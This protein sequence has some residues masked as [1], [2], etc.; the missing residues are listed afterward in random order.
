MLG[1]NQ[2]HK[3]LR[4][5]AQNSVAVIATLV[6]TAQLAAAQDLIRLPAVADLSSQWG[7]LA[8]A[9]R[10]E[11]SNTA[12]DGVTDGGD[13]GTGQPARSGQRHRITLEQ[14]K[15]QSANRVASP[16]AHMS[17][18][19]VEAARQHRLGVQADYF[20]K[21]G[22]TFV[23]LHFTDFLGQIIQVRRP[24]LGTVTEVPAPIIN[25]NLTIAALT[26]VQ[27]ITPLF[28]VR[29]AVRI[30]RADERI[31]IAKAAASISKNARDSEIEANY[32]KLLIAQR[33][34][35]SAEWK[36]QSAEKRL[37]KASAFVDLVQISGQGAETPGARKEVETAA[38]TVRELAA[39][40]NRVMDWP[41]DTELDLT[42]PDPLVE[43]VSLQEISDKS[44][45]VNPAL[46]EAEQTVVK[47]RA[48]YSISKMAYFPTVAA[49]AG[50]LF[51]NAFP[52]VNSN[53]GYG[54]VM[55]SYTLFDFGKREHAIKE[56]HAQL[57][58][59]ETALQLTKAKI[60]ADVKKSYFELERSRQ[61]SLVA[62]K[63]GSST[64]LLIKV[65]AISESLEV[66]A[67]RAEVE[68]EMI[69]AD[70]AHRQAFNRL[71][72]LTGSER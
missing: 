24:V 30:A 28:E 47:A 52:A 42:M 33:Q 46:V 26:F 62:Q 64:A 4:T 66:K 60:G 13:P 17:Q 20:P 37:Q 21:F 31:A 34:L 10:P 57:E 19:A 39:S 61:L 53:F 36:A 38:A 41:D 5:I 22:A 54:G 59:A 49:V 44:T 23:N 50:Y 71:K 55:A 3:H 14:V 35:I 51:Q 2:R 1:S 58:M 15:Q 45:A 72:A 63:M 43:N 9:K 69:E 18:L 56:A 27:P 40:L 25:Q 65:S 6:L 70:F 48:A 12:L 16:M 68:V 67:A 32:F 29:Q 8:T 11:A 7:A